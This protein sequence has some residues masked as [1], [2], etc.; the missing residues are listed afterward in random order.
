MLRTDYTSY[1]RLL[2]FFDRYRP[3]VSKHFS[4]AVA[5][6]EGRI[7]LDEARL[8]S[9]A[10]V[11]GASEYVYFDVAGMCELADSRGELALFA[12]LMWDLAQHHHHLAYLF[13]TAYPRAA[14]R[15]SAVHDSI[16]RLAP[17]LVSAGRHG[18]TLMRAALDSE[19]AGALVERARHFRTVA[20]NGPALLP[21]MA[22]ILEEKR[23]I[24]PAD[25]LRRWLARGASL[26]ESGRLEEAGAFLRFQSRESRALLGLRYA[27]LTDVRTVLSIYAASIASREVAVRDLESSGFEGERPVTDGTTLF[28]PGR[29][30][31]FPSVE[32]NEKVYT[33]L[34][35]LNAG[36]IRF[37][38]FGFRL[39][40]VGGLSEI[41]ERFG[42]LLPDVMETLRR[43]YR[44]QSVRL[45]ERI[46]GE[47]ELHYP[48]GVSVELLR[49]HHEEFSFLFPTPDFAAELWSYLEYRRVA[50]ILSSRYRGFAR[51]LRE[52]NAEI[53][54]RRAARMRALLTAEADSGADLAREFRALVEGIVEEGL[55]GSWH[56]KGDVPRLDERIRDASARIRAALARAAGPA[57]TAQLTFELYSEW[58]EHYPLV[59]L[60]AHTKA[61][62]LFA[63]VGAGVIDPP[64]AYRS[65]PELFAGERERPRFDY[66]MN[67][68]GEREVDLTSLSRH[69]AELDSLRDTL[70]HGSIRTYRYREYDNT[71]GGYRSAHCTLRESTLPPGEPSFY[72]DTLRAHDLVFRRIR[73]RFLYL[74]PEE[75]SR[76]RRW[77]DGESI[78]LSDAVDLATDILRGAGG[79]EKI[80]ERVMQNRRDIVAAILVDSSSSTEEMVG[81]RRVIDI[82]RE[83]VCLLSSALHIVG[84]AFGVY[85]FFS[86]GR[87][88]VFCNVIKELRE[89]WT[90]AEQSRIA[91]MEAHAGNR[92]GCAIRHITS[93]LLQAPQRS[94]LL[95]LLS[96]GIPADAGYGSKRGRETGEYAIEDTRRAIDEARQ[97]GITPFCITVD[98]FAR[99]Y[100]PRLYGRHCAIINDIT[101]LPERIGRIY[102]RLTA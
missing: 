33:V 76:S 99:N 5:D 54:R 1:K 73:K 46:S 64:L 31:L 82:E 20:R 15:L 43:R 77:L 41:R 17:E 7:T 6:L 72:T 32:A 2:A 52:L 39:E 60:F 80:Y 74:K 57:A 26:L 69:E 101:R 100:I 58:F 75:R 71:L 68:P 50:A 19:S 8:R 92:D 22:R 94:K 49:T 13:V 84:D 87:S 97:A 9:V 102:A 3:R 21:D 37:G 23:S 81:D 55:A 79:D 47:V 66:E 45:Q 67:D 35:G 85:A 36:I 34:A 12:E 90:R 44:G 16:A 14:W 83:A 51:D 86:M 65:S 25:L 48:G 62:S 28:L 24:L 38:S 30:R 96:D 98:R 40:E 93:K 89:P 18:A 61:A 27:V 95:L 59:P 70:V 11:A 88:N 63:G 53:W 42:T 4:N 91:S 56:G 78:N 29:M 10:K